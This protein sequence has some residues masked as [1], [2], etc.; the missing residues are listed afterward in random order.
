MFIIGVTG[1]IGTGKSSLAKCFAEYGIRVLDADQ[2]SHEVTQAKGAALPEIVE[3]FG[4]EIID[5]TG[6]MDRQ[7]MSDLVFRDKKALDDLS[8]IVHHHV[9]ETIKKEVEKSRKKEK[10]MLLDVP[11]PVKDGFLNLSD[12]VICVVADDEIRR[13]RLIERGMDP[14]DIERRFL[15]QMSQEEY[16]ELADLVYD[17]SGTLE[18]LQAFVARYVEEEL[19]T[20]GIA[21]KKRENLGEN[22]SSLPEA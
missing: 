10:V 8:F 15:M 9:I 13:K 11:I 6:A 14:E 3:R 22:T 16:K 19:K 5:E 17:N 1:A 12:Q 4:Q 7:A 18:Q 20:R 21:L 2:I